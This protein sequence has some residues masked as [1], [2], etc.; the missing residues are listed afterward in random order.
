MMRLDWLKE[1]AYSNHTNNTEAVDKRW[2][3]VKF[4]SLEDMETSSVITWMSTT[5]DTR[6]VK[7]GVDTR[8]VKMGSI[9][10]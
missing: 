9:A 5:V 10:V 6:D 1:E 3:G 7:M 4:P 8:D 2:K